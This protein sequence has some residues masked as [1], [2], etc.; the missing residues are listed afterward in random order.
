[1]IDAEPRHEG[2]AEAGGSHGQDPVVTFAFVDGAPV[3]LL[4]VE[5]R[6]DRGAVFAMGARQIALAVEILD[7]HVGTLRQAMERLHH[8]QILLAIER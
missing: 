6:I 4:L 1:M 3:H 5:D 8:D 7:P 2:E